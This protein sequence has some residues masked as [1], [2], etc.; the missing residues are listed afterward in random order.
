MNKLD[1]VLS[2]KATFTNKF[3][4]KIFNKLQVSREKELTVFSSSHNMNN[5]NKKNPLQKLPEV[6]VLQISLG[7]ADMRIVP[8]GSTGKIG[9]N[10]W[11]LKK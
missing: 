8:F 4:K 6:S 5:K 3:I 7:P 11:F 9:R 2:L 10:F 1:T